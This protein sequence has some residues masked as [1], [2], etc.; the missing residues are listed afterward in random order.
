M[1]TRLTTTLLLA[2]ILAWCP[3]AP[4]QKKKMKANRPGNDPSKNLVTGSRVAQKVTTLTKEV[5][6]HTSLEEAKK[7]ARAEQKAIFWLHA[8]GDLEGET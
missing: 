5:H 8:L 2:A 3:P 6:W 7:V 1:R 4:A